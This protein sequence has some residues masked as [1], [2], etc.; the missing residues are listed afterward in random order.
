[1]A[2]VHLQLGAPGWQ[3]NPL[4]LGFVGFVDHVAP[5]LER[6]E[7][8]N[9]ELLAEAWDQVDGNEARRR[10]GL[11]A[12]SWQLFDTLGR[13]LVGF[14]QPHEAIRFD[15]LPPDEDAVERLYTPGSGITIQGS[16]VTRFVYRLGM[17]PSLPAGAYRLRVTVRDYSGN[18]ASKDLEFTSNAISK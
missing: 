11:Y 1:M 4:A 6:V 3:R 14:E 16:K 12:L 2:H 15:A 13:P 8:K 7:L 18:E 17:L 10:L 5:H 9:G